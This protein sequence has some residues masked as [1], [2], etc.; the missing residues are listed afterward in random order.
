MK[1]NINPIDLYPHLSPEQVETINNH[2]VDFD[3]LY[4]ESD[5]LNFKKLNDEANLVSPIL[6]SGWPQSDIDAIN[7]VTDIRLQNVLIAR[8][9]PLGNDPEN[10]LSDDELLESVI[11]RNL[12]SSEVED[13]A[14]E[15]KWLKDESLRLAQEIKDNRPV[16]SSNPPANE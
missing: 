8:L 1:T 3:S 9:Q 12:T 15:Y 16:E 6:S 13:Y 14:S 11:R 10:N 4:S 7:E 5:V 2:T